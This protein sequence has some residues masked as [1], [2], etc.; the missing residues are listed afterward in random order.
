MRIASFAAL[1]EVRD[2][3]DVDLGATWPAC[4]GMVFQV[5]RIDHP[6]FQA[7]IGKIGYEDA[8]LG[9]KALLI[10]V[11][12]EAATTAIA[13]REDLDA[14]AKEAE[15]NRAAAEIGSRQDPGVI[16]AI[17]RGNARREERER[18]A[19]ALAGVRDWTGVLDA[20]TGK[21]APCDLH[22]RLELL[23][24]TGARVSLEGQAD[25]LMTFDE[26]AA[27]E[28]RSYLGTA[29]A[30]KRATVTEYHGGLRNEAGLLYT[31]GPGLPHAGLPVGAAIT[32][33]LIAAAREARA[34]AVKKE[35][36]EV[37][38]LVPTSAG[39]AAAPAN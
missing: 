37:A 31:I 26:L 39:A 16:A 9:Q 6:E 29:L 38:A 24:W 17:N 34:K 15:I 22:H 3:V 11:E 19:L 7:E 8:V 21:P 27:V 25:Q 28:P 23:G 30:A 1:S 33:V 18:R 20:E 32:K 12:A 10:A 35:D 5:L 13:A 2:V 4:A 36:A 14:A